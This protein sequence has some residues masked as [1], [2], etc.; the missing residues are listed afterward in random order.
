MKIRSDFVLWSLIAFEIFILSSLPTYGQDTTNLFY[1]KDGTIITGKI[2]A[3]DDSTLVLETEYGTME[4]R[5]MDVVKQ[6]EALKLEE[7]N[8]QTIRLRDGTTIKG[9]VIF[10]NEDSLEVETL[11]GVVKIPKSSIVINKE[12]HQA[13]HQLGLTE[14][15]KLALYEKQNKS[16]VIAACASCLLPSLGHAYAENWSRGVP[17]AVLRMAF[18][19]LVETS[20]EET[21]GGVSG[22]EFQTITNPSGYY[23]GIIGYFA[24]TLVEVIDAAMQVKK[25]NKKLM[26]MIQSGKPGFG[27]NV[28]PSKDGVYLRVA[29]HF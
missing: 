19:I 26:N 21:T 20:Y 22:Y 24:T 11:H 1:L 14:A 17:F 12:E 6:E 4:I 2:I 10:E 3:Q 15:E 29:Y 23:I 7:K 16:Y 25:Y 13:D 9:I 27:M 28:L 18:F 5:K 8:I